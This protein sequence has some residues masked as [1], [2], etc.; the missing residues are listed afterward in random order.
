MSESLKTHQGFP[1]LATMGWLVILVAGM[2]AADSIL[3]PLLLSGFLAV[4]CAGPVFWLVRKGAPSTLAVLLVILGLLGVGLSIGAM[5]GT[6]ANDFSQA[7]PKYETRLHEKMGGIL[8]W[9]E[10]GGIELSASDLFSY[11]DPG[12]AMQ[13]GATMLK[14][15]GEM[16]TNAFLIL[17]TVIFILLEACSLTKKWQVVCGGNQES[18]ARFATFTYDIQHLL[19]IKTAVSIGTGLAVGIWVAVL[20]IDFPVLWGVL[21]FLLNYIPNLGS[22]IAGTPA[23]LLAFIQF[24]IGRAFLVA[25]GYIIIN[26]L[27]GNIIE[28]R[29]MGR[30]LGLSTLT[31]FLSLV[32]WGWV[33]GPVGMILSVPLTMVVK[34][35]LERNPETRWIALLLGSEAALQEAQDAVAPS[36]GVKIVS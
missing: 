8:K 13:L 9:L 6:S 2:R 24:G 17:L 29:I 22:I 5:I 16:L 11:I 7:L 28:P 1:L 27:F 19:A 10:I 20:G 3:V 26:I 30:R 35:A 25:I 18:F 36:D 4:I 33:W 14:G 23:V 15:L 31:V 34:I 32:F 12:A 21:A